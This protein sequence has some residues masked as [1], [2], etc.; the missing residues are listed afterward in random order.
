MKI[1]Y[2]F[3]S[4]E[5]TTLTKVDHIAGHISFASTPYDFI[6]VAVG[7]RNSMIRRPQSE[8]VEMFF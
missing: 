1:D 4:G 3:S 5:P 2:C 7:L 8:D 6:F